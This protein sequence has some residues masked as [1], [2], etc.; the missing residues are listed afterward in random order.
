MVKPNL[1]RLPVPTDRT[2][3]V[4]RRVLAVAV[5]VFAVWLTVAL[6]RISAD[7]GRNAEAL[8]DARSERADLRERNAAQDEEI[9]KRDNAV[10]EAN[11]K[12]KDAGEEPVTVSGQPATTPGPAGAPVLSSDDVLTLIEA[13]VRSQQPT[14]SESQRARIVERAAVA[15]AGRIPDPEP[16]EDGTDGRDA[17]SLDTL[18]PVIRAEVATIPAPSDGAPGRAPTEAEVSSAVASLCGGSCKGETGDRGEPGESVT[19][20]RGE[21]GESVTGPRGMPG[22]SV[23]GP[24]GDRGEPGAD[25]TVPGPPGGDGQDGADGSDG[26]GIA[27]LTCDGDRFVV[28]WSDGTEQTTN[29]VCSTEPA[30]EPE[31][32]DPPTTEPEP[33][34]TSTDVVPT[35]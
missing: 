21:P 14:L 15:A 13:E 32:S 20:P 27:S 26:R 12:L 23:T 17:P 4:L 18:R 3:R 7:A 10:G 22:E 25:S 8:Q 19:G 29:A 35:P 5:A 31:P 11:E 1:D 6:V 33:E 28:T 34:P 24:K 16:G 30:P 9:A 2:M